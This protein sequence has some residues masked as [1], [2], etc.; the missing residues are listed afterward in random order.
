MGGRQFNEVLNNEGSVSNP[1]EKLGMVCPKDVV[2]ELLAA[3]QDGKEKDTEIHFV[4]SLHYLLSS[5]IKEYLSI[6]FVIY[7]GAP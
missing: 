7:S 4:V 5:S 6:R 2:C 1:E 3:S